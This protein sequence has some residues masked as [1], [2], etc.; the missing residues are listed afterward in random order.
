MDHAREASEGEGSVGQVVDYFEQIAPEYD[1][2]R[3]GGEYGRFVDAE[4][5][6]ILQSWL[7]QIPTEEVLDAGCG[8]GRFLDFADHGLDPSARMLEIAR[9]KHPEKH[10]YHGTFSQV[11]SS[12]GFPESFRAI[13]S[14]HVLMHFTA[15]QTEEFFSWCAE[16]LKPGGLLIIGV[17]SKK[18]RRLRQGLGRYRPQGWH[19]SAPLST[20]DVRRLAEGRFQLTGVRGLHL[21]PN[22][23]WASA[24]RPVLT[25]LERAMSA[26]AL[27]DYYRFLLLRLEKVS[28]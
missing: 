4:E 8:T 16:H 10:L 21:C 28:D 1:S 26:T 5:R 12:L 9:S 25:P 19:G 3:F 7:S 2:S 18:R 22:K 17:L 24:L 11:D 15:E 20:G 27:A 6:R 13:I 14:M 23:R